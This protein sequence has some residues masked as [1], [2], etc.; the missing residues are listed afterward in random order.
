MTISSQTYSTLTNRD[1]YRK[2]HG[3]RS[4]MRSEHSKSGPNLPSRLLRPAHS[5][6]KHELIGSRIPRAGSILLSHSSGYLPIALVTPYVIHFRI[7][8]KI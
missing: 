1:W 3:A 7:R 8:K 4:D 5:L 6:L 2:I